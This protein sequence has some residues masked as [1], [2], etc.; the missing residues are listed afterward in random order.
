MD[1]GHTRVGCASRNTVSV[2][3]TAY[4][5]QRYVAEALESVI[6]QS[7]A[8][9]EIILVDDGSTDETYATALAFARDG[10]R[11]ITRDNGGPSRAFNHG[12]RL[13]SGDI[14]VWFSADDVLTEHSLRSRVDALAGGLFDVACSPPL[15]IDEFGRELDPCEMG[16]APHF[17]HFRFASASG[18]FARLYFGGNFICAPS[19]AMTRRCWL[20]VGELNAGLLQLQDFE[21]WLRVCAMKMRFICLDEPCVMYRWHG[22][23][24]SRGPS[25]RS[26]YEMEGIVLNAPGMLDNSMKREI[27]FGE[28]FTDLD[29]PLCSEELTMLILYKHS[30]PIA[31]EF[32]RNELRRLVLDPSGFERLRSGIL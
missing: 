14:I 26:H 11:V 1:S 7:L 20:S 31:R 8:P 30:L 29:L 32:A 13:S 17:P 22:K 18:F 10:I 19:V 6:G 5:H 25:S 28:N 4:N 2:V 23:N 27:L 12:A 15:W 9:D 16:A 24:L 3:I 21:Y